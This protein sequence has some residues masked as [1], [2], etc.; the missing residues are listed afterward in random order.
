MRLLRDS[1]TVRVLTTTDSAGEPHVV[2]KSFIGVDEME[3]LYVLE[4]LE[5]SQTNHN[6]VHSLWFSHRVAI[7]LRGKGDEDYE[8]K[9]LP[10]RC[11]ISGPVFERYYRLMRESLGDADL[12][13]VWFI[14]P[15]K[16][17]DETFWV[18]SHEE[19]EAHP[20]FMHLDRIAKR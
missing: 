5:S 13:A 15:E 8:I 3:G 1:E 14:T 17:R 4:L 19:A 16:I 6:L 9:G 2:F 7:G 11:V 18:R 10:R 20:L 12:A